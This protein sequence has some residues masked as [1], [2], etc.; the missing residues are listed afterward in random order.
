MIQSAFLLGR[1]S[2]GGR[3][4]FSMNEL[5][6]KPVCLYPACAARAAGAERVSLLLPPGDRRLAAC[7]P[8]DTDVYEYGALPPQFSGA[9]GDFLL[10]A[11]DAVS[12]IPAQL[13]ALAA[14]G[15]VALTCEGRFVAGVAGGGQLAALSDADSLLRADGLERMEA[16][17][18]FGEPYLGFRTLDQRGLFELSERMRMDILYHWMDEGV[19]IVSADGVLIGPDVQIGADTVILPGTEL[20]GDTRIGRNCVIGPNSVLTGSTVGDGCTVESSKLTNAVLH[21]GVRIGPFSQLR[22]NTELMSGVKVGD[23]VEIKN[24]RIGAHTAVAHLTYVG[25]SDVGERVNFGCGVVTCNY[26]GVN[27]H[28]TVI[29]DGAFIGCNTNLVAPVEVGAGAYTAAGTTVTRDVPADALAVGR[30]R[31]ELHEDWASQFKERK[32]KEKK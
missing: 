14:Y 15:R 9:S 10:L 32:R 11:D 28:R 12:L 23:F 16:A 30:A 21:D 31:Q 3:I 5:L 29:G 6:F 27:K 24:S 13:A 26:D 1:R 7:F 4:P 20:R 18:F 2:P 8:S 19:A 22:P 25:D 17:E